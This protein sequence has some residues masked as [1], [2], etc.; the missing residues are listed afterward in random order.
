[1]EEP[2]NISYCR[3]ASE[4]SGAAILK[5]R[6]FV[7]QR[8]LEPYAFKFL[9]MNGAEKLSELDETLKLGV[10]NQGAQHDVV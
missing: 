1:M 3:G 6:A 9:P 8:L 5:Y 4:A 2:G 10:L 7:L